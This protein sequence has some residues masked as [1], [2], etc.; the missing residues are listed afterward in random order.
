[1]AES[2]MIKL[3]PKEDEKQRARLGNVFQS[4]ELF[5]TGDQVAAKNCV[6]QIGLA[7]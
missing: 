4:R 1:M 5:A 3:A 6:R 7:T 2:L